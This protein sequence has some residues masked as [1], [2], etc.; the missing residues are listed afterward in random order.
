MLVATSNNSKE[1]HVRCAGGEEKAFNYWE[2]IMNITISYPANEDNFVPLT[3]NASIVEDSLPATLNV[4]LNDI[5]GKL[6]EKAECL[7]WSP[8]E[9]WRAGGGKKRVQGA[10]DRDMHMEP[11][12]P[13]KD[14]HT[15]M[16][17]GWLR[18]LSHLSLQ[19]V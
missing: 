7:I 12:G 18:L 17:P 4:T 5:C 6:H 15:H 14:K 13:T 2:A 10:S 8:L 19:V 9:Y 3:E 11:V 1:G 16:L